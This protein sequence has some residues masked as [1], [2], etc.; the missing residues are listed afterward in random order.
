MKRLEPPGP[1][2]GLKK[3]LIYLSRTNA[4]LTPF[5]EEKKRCNYRLD[6]NGVD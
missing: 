6:E 1:C 2:I 3:P 4:A 5:E